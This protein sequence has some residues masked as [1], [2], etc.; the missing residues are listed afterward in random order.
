MTFIVLSH[1]SVAFWH[2]IN[3]KV[4]TPFEINDSPETPLFEIDRDVQYYMDMH[5]TEY[6]KCNYDFVNRFNGKI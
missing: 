2:E 3:K 1:L 4:F 5:Y 6:V